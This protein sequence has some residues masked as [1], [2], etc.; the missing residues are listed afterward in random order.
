MMIIVRN[1]KD[2]NVGYKKKYF[3][4]KENRL[5]RGSM[6]T[7]MEYMNHK[8]LDVTKVKD[9]SYDYTLKELQLIAQANSISYSGLNKDQLISALRGEPIEEEEEEGGN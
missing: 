4:M 9:F 5:V 2:Y 1:N 8:E 6:E 3:P 7:L